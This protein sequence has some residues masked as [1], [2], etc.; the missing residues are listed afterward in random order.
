MF[1]VDVKQQNNNNNNNDNNNNDKLVTITTTVHMT[2][3]EVSVRLTIISSLYVEQIA[4][5]IKLLSGSFLYMPRSHFKDNIVTHLL[6]TS[7]LVTLC[8]CIK[9]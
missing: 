9:T 7:Y 5:L 2:C 4:R 3:D 1:T 8:A 6:S